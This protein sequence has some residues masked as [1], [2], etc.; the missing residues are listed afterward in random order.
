MLQFFPQ[1]FFNLLIF[2]SP[3]NITFAYNLILFSLGILQVECHPYLNQSKLLDFCK[4]HDIVLVAFGALGSQRV[5][6]WY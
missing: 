1:H 4:S 3:V 6:E 5:K 2:L